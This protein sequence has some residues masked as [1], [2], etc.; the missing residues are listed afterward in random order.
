MDQAAR[1]MQGQAIHD[2]LTALISYQ[3]GMNDVV[4]E[5]AGEGSFA[6]AVVLIDTMENEI[7]R[8]GGDPV[9]L[10]NALGDFADA[11]VAA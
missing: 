4:L 6:A 3:A 7:R 11:C 9:A 1:R 5:L 10:T 2:V 8:L